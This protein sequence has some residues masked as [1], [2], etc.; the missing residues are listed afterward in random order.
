MPDA[1]LLAAPAGFLPVTSKHLELRSL[2]RDKLECHSCLTAACHEKALLDLA[3]P[4]KIDWQTKTAAL[5]KMQAWIHMLTMD[6]NVP[7]LLMQRQMHS[8]E[9][10]R[11]LHNGMRLMLQM[12]AVGTDKFEAY[13]RM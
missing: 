4:D 5:W 13:F 12:A 3:F 8:G 11:S 2:D 6:R 1:L 7:D 9:S 10:N